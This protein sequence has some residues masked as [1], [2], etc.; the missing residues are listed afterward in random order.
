MRPLILDQQV[1][2][3]QLLDYLVASEYEFLHDHEQNIEYALVFVVY[4]GEDVAGYIWF[5]QLEEDESSWVVHVAALPGHRKQFFTRTLVNTVLSTCYALGCN[6][7]IAE[8][9][10]KEYL[11]RMGGK[12]DIN[13]CIVL[14]LPKTWR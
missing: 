14:E 6:R 10:G 1:T 5:Y 11:E 8:N 12:P 7:V 13:G 9:N 2:R 4:Q 3:Q